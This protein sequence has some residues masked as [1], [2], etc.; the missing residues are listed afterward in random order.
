MEQ[1]WVKKETAESN[2]G[3][4]RL[5]R[6]LEAMLEVFEERPGRYLTTKFQE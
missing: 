3:D 4:A 2:F 1:S 6:R 5:N